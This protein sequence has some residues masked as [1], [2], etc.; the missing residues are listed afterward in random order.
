MPITVEAAPGGRR[1]DVVASGALTQPERLAALARCIEL[2]HV[3]RGAG[4][5]FDARA[6]VSAPTPA[7]NHEI[8]EVAGSAAPVFVAGVAI[9]IAQA[10]Q[11]GMARMLQS[12]LE[13]RGVTVAVFTDITAATSW[14][15]T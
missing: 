15:G 11:Y 3:Q 14:L 12:L 1:V 2:L 6:A 7:E 8:M 5:L 10:V 9:V 4:V 13:G